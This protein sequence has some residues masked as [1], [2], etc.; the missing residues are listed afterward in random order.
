LPPRLPARRYWCARA[1]TP[2]QLTISKPL[3]IEG[4]QSGNNDAA[5]ITGTSAVNAADFD[6]G[7]SPIITQILV[8]NTSYVNL[9]NLTTD[10]SSIR[11]TDVEPI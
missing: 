2:E 6:A 3:T 11:S 8:E 1:S 10:G 9:I 4:I 7:G 5:I